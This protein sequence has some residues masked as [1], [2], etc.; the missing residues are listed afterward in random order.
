MNLVHRFQRY[1]QET[2][3]ISVN[4][5][6]LLA[7]SGGR[8]SMLMA[9]LFLAAGYPCV[10][11]HCNFHLREVDAD[12]DEQLVKEFAEQHKVPFF[13]RHF[14]TN[15]YAEEYGL[16]TQMAAR[17]LR[18]A[19]FKELREQQ[20]ALWIAIAQHQD[21]HIET[22]LLNLT[23]GTGLQGLQGILPKRGNII[24][25]ILFLSSEEITTSVE[26]LQIPFRDDQSN[27]STKYARNKVRLEIIPKFREISPEFDDIMC[28]N[29]V[30]FQEAYDLLQSFVVPIRNESFIPVGSLI[31]ISKAKLEPHLQ[32][33]PLLFELFKPYGFS[34]S[35]L[36]DMR[37]HW[38]GEPGKIFCSTQYELLLDREDV[39]LKVQKE[40]QCSHVVKIHV[41]TAAFSFANREFAVSI[42]GDTSLRRSENV[43]QA[44]FEKLQFPLVLRF[45]K[46]GDYF[47]PLGMGGKRKK[48]SDYFIQ[49]K[50]GRYE[51]DTIPIL[52]NGNGDVLWIVNY[53]ADNR[54]KI[55]KS[56]K[57][58]FT[59]VCK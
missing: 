56:T 45:W 15:D 16:S 39:W 51:K 46:E 3:G 43:L 34:K 23:R 42:D 8:D 28:E 2:L 1:M 7:V 29:I 12:L 49:K 48:V 32:R 33:L 53:R 27:F 57:K 41:D 26:E 52:I 55:T 25:P 58:V 38:N 54:Y 10:I 37:K 5:K 9:H 18:Y 30:H 22:V 17:E 6:V 35:V 50:I 31:R 4:D 24:R 40:K 59:L 21:D 14:Q 20:G 13:V 47:Y 36:A 19:W 11:A 44:D